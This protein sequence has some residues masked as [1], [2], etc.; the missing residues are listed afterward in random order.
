[1]TMG[2]LFDL[3][4]AIVGRG[5]GGA[6]LLCLLLLPLETHAACSEKLA[7]IDRKLAA[8]EIDAVLAPAIEQFRDRGAEACAQGHEPTAMQTL[9]I[10]D[11]MLTRITA[12]RA[13]T[14]RRAAPPP[15]PPP[16]PS[17]EAQLA[18]GRS[19]FPNR[20]DRL[21]QVG[22]CQWLTTKELERE[23]TFRAPLSCRDTGKGFRIEASV[24][25]DDWPE[26]VFMLIVEVH[27]TQETVR[28]A[29][30]NTSQ[31][32]STRLFTPFDVGTPELNVYLANRGHYLY[33]FPAGGLT[34]W[35]LEYLRPGPKRDRYY[36]PSPGRSGNADLGPRFMEM[37]VDKFSEWL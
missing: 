36:A 35:R 18:A 15:P 17:I 29:E 6:C 30:I 34:L 31:G 2:R 19:D 27:P 22:F 21:S 12:E 1:M 24:E 8:T 13:E 5:L 16:G 32:F 7:E 33:A 14:E 23:L 9:G 25:G 3:G 4:R 20:W 11:L 37:L 28:R 26:Q 10:V